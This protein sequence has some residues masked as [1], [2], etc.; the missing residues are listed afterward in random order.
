MSNLRRLLSVLVV[1]AA[2]LYTL[3]VLAPAAQAAFRYAAHEQLP[4]CCKD[5]VSHCAKEMTGCISAVCAA[6][7][8]NF[9]AEPHAQFSRP[10]YS[11]DVSFAVHLGGGPPGTNQPP[12]LPP[13]IA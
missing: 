6:P 11:E 9:V 12:P 2:T 5:I 1:V 7:C 13:P 3:G 8:V 10:V 4:D